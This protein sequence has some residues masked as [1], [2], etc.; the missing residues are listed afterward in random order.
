MG[1]KVT[2]LL[3]SPPLHCPL[4]QP[5]ADQ[6]RKCLR[7]YTY[8]CFQFPVIS[9]VSA[10]LHT[11][12]DDLVQNLVQHL[13]SPVQWMACMDMMD[14][15]GVTLAIEM[16]TKSILTSMMNTKKIRSICFNLSQGLPEI[17]NI[18][19]SQAYRCY[20]ASFVEGCLA[21]AVATANR[22]WD[23]EQ[24]QTAVID[25]YKA[26]HDMQLYLDSSGEK[27]GEDQ[28]RRAFAS[29]Q[30]ILNAKQVPE[31]EQKRKLKE[32]VNATGTQD[33]FETY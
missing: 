20:R 26:I 11:S 7:Q 32:I 1:G 18:V 17:R 28:M 29:L 6:F 15:F 8:H 21:N 30:T 13:V 12:P 19:G 3:T 2:P 9:N 33:I 24:Y 16:N 4:M 27:P 14:R 10:G 23:D 25:E 5:Y 31:N 22:N